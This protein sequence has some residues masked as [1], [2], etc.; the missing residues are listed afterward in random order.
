MCILAVG[1]DHAV[2]CDALHAFA[3]RVDDRVEVGVNIGVVE[4]DVVDDQRV[5]AVV[6]ELRSL[7]EERGVVLIALDDELRPVAELEVLIEVERNAAHNHARIA[8]RRFE[9]P[10][11]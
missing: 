9:Q 6:Q 11:H 7:V 3:E 2:R 8:P 1:D 5:R 4:L 10:R